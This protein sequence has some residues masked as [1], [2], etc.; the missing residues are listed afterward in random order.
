MTIG[1][2]DFGHSTRHSVLDRKGRITGYV[3]AYDDGKWELEGDP[4][5]CNL[6]SV[7]LKNKLDVCNRIEQSTKRT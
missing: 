3:V 2:C 1:N 6:L 7:L 4:F 5:V